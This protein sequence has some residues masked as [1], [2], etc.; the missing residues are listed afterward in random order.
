MPFNKMEALRKAEEHVSR[1][2]I[3]G[4]IAIHR[5]IVQA[6]P[7]DLTTINALGELYVSAGRTKEAIDDF[8]R[9]ADGYLN[10]GSGIKA[11]YLL[12]KALDLDPSN[13]PVLMNLGEIYL[14]EGM[15]EKA[16][17]EFIRAG[18]L[19]ADAG[20]LTGALQAN[21][22]ALTSKPGSPQA[23]AAIAGLQADVAA[24]DTSS[25]VS[26]LKTGTGGLRTS[27]GTDSASP[28]QASEHME[29]LSTADE[30]SLIRQLSKAEMLVGY[31]D[32]DQ[33]IVLLKEVVKRSPDNLDV[34]GKLKD[35]YLRNEMIKDAERECLELARIHEA[36]GESARATEYTLRATRLAHSGSARLE[37]PTGT[38]PIP[39]RQMTDSGIQ[40][41][42][43]GAEP[44]SSQRFP[45]KASAPVPSATVD[46]SA[47]I[48]RETEAP[49]STVLPIEVAP[50]GFQTVHI[51]AEPQAVG[52]RVPPPP[53]AQP[54]AAR[55]ETQPQASI[56]SS[57]A[58]RST[59]QGEPSVQPKRPV[60]ERGPANLELHVRETTPAMERLLERS[61]IQA[62]TPS[63]S[64]SLVVPATLALASRTSAESPGRRPKWLYVA[65]VAL[66]AVMAIT[67]GALKGASMY[68][69]QLDRKYEELASLAS[70]DAGY[71]PPG[72][73]S[74]EDLQLLGDR[75]AVKI[76]VPPVQ[77]GT[78]TSSAAETQ[79]LTA[80]RLSEQPGPKAVPAAITEQP[81]VNK[82]AAASPPLVSL[83]DQKGGESF[84]PRGL[85]TGA[86][87]TVAAAPSPPPLP[88][89]QKRASAVVKGEAIKQGQPD[90]PAMARNAR[91]EGMVPVEISINENGDVVSARAISG[92]LL[93]RGPAESAA[94][95][96]KFR[97]ST[98]DGKPVPTV[99]TINFRFKL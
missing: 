57:S 10:S 29:S 25:L 7:Y 2:E 66:V 1:G 63:S 30:E 93:L 23:K 49:S 77:I 15:I 79:K 43:I 4:A 45:P 3:T 35:I 72:L 12:R 21:H 56:I 82:P 65:P 86:P 60:A 19:L 78:A 69:V 68:G 84:E 32:V 22:R 24:S 28:R 61:P 96:W 98:R 87:Q 95:R 13:A 5:M 52:A 50:T 75:E 74:N 40:R 20:Q 11:A 91:Q 17:D 76:D 36:R 80:Q 51:Q 38:P 94:R 58:S 42:S 8:T 39:S 70:G 88:I 73:P 48:H 14:R 46:P 9:I 16:H 54:L 44:A 99:T 97:P 90:Y 33:A 27:S 34:H 64:K 59:V 53:A 55:R 6:D 81:R 71:S 89:P 67:L 85:P 31:G 18:A 92:P 62:E 26:Q 37:S 83:A 41:P 47:A